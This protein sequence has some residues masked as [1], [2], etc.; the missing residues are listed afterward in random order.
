MWKVNTLTL[1]YKISLSLGPTLPLASRIVVHW[2]E[3][4]TTWDPF[5]AQRIP[6][7]H[8]A[9]H[10]PPTTVGNV[11][12]PSRTRV[13]LSTTRPPLPGYAGGSVAADPSHR[14]A[15][16]VPLGPRCQ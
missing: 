11:R 15:G 2:S 3:A 1:F 5:P 4:G 12:S 14:H 6:R 10:W 7:P 13:V 9:R 8:R 16:F